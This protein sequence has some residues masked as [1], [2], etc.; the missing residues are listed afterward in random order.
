MQKDPNAET[1]SYYHSLFRGRGVLGDGLGAFRDGVLGQLARQDQTDR[2]LDFPRGN[3][4]L[5][6]VG[7]KLRGLSGNALE[8]V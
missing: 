3:S 7:G 4:R 6:V 1:H 5:L 2:G 8:D